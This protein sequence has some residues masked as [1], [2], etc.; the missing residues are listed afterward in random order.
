MKKFI[1]LSSFMLFTTSCF[2][3]QLSGSADNNG[4]NTGQTIDNAF[5]AQALQ[6]LKTNCSSC[7]G[8]TTGPANVYG[9]DDPNHLVSSG[10]IE[11]GD[12]N[13]SPLFMPIADGSM[14]PSKPVSAADQL[15][16]QNW[17]ANVATTQ[18]TPTPTPPPLPTPTPT[19]TP[20]PT[21]GE[22][23][24][25]E[26][27][28]KILSVKCTS[29]HNVSTYARVMKWVSAGNPNSSKLYKEVKSGSMPKGS[30]KLTTAQ[31]QSIYNWILAGAK[32]N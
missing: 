10:L 9:L 12:P 7:H 16:I 13:R 22:P 17:I 1:I 31:V 20:P 18:P 2:K 26:I 11:P 30:S 5:Q 4:G 3:G 14:P 25:S 28:T 19:P 8:S 27:S 6:I 24:Y 23:K 29:C 15:V 21:S 32:N